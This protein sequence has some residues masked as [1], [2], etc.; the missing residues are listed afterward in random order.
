M[1]R[2][3]DPRQKAEDGGGVAGDTRA[4]RV[5]WDIAPLVPG[6]TVAVTR[7]EASLMK[8]KIMSENVE[9]VRFSP[10]WATAGTDLAQE[11]HWRKEILTCRRENRTKQD[12]GWP[13]VCSAPPE[14][15]RE[16]LQELQ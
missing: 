7:V 9:Y 12:P 15:F 5:C 1:K 16:K 4:G 10:G 3:L 11:M 13:D 6:G 8:R 2:G 14:I